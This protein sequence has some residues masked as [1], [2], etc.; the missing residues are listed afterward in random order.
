L[1]GAGRLLAEV[2]DELA[3]I[4]DA[5]GNH[6]YLE[7]LEHGLVSRS[8]L[9]T[10]AEEQRLIIASDG[11][12]FENLA[13]RFVEPPSGEFFAWMAEGEFEALEKLGA[14]A[15][16]VGANDN[17]YSPRP[18]CH[19]YAAYVAWL[20]LH[21][22]R[23]DVALAFLANLAAWG[24]SCA[25]IARVL[26]GRY[27]VSFFEFFASS[28]PDFEERALAVLEQGLAAGERSDKARGAA[29]LLQA[30][31]LMYWDTLHDAL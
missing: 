16:D 10:F 9:R 5:I 26:R 6:R 28:P 1:I 31:E 24:E 15:A 19:A 11:R 2:R 25:R 30:Y 14:F 29:R 13:A 17:S 18:G 8:N 22:S 4:E 3:P 27:D 20:A 23:A 21:G 12:S 7:A